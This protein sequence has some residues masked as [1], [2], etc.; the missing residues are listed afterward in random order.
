MEHWDRVEVC[1]RADGS[2][3]VLGEGRFG[4]VHPVAQHP[5]LLSNSYIY[6]F[7]LH[8]LSVV[9]P[10]RDPAGACVMRLQFLL[11]KAILRASR[12]AGMP[13]RNAV[14]HRLHACSGVQRSAE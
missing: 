4:K 9:Q 14:P 2:A 5:I 10:A 11:L 13:C 7:L 1:R 3:W 8:S 6:Y 12:Y